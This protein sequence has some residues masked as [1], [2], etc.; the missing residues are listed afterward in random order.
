MEAVIPA[1]FVE[2]G[3][4]VGEGRSPV[5]YFDGADAHER[6]DNGPLGFRVVDLLPGGI[7][8]IPVAED[9]VH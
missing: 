8:G 7:L 5:Q 1:G 2:V 9:R 6:C 4:V 3:V